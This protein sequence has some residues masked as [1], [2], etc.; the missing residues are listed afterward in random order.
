MDEDNILA[1]TI[2]VFLFVFGI[3]TMYF[4]W[5]HQEEQLDSNYQLI[6]VV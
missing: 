4:G 6:D 2:G 5:R 1:I 3:I